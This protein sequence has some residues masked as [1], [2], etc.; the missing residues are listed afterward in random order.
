MEYGS[1]MGGRGVRSGGVRALCLLLPR[2]RDGGPRRRRLAAKGEKTRDAGRFQ[3]RRRASTGVSNISL[4]IARLP[5]RDPY[6]CALRCEIGSANAGWPHWKEVSNA[7]PYGLSNGSPGHLHSKEPG[8]KKHGGKRRIRPSI[9]GQE[10]RQ[11]GCP[12]A[13]LHCLNSSPP[14]SSLS[15]GKDAE[16]RNLAVVG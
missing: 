6:R 9:N 12:R 15:L 7:P 2:G 11:Q 3:S 4:P 1:R 14:G 5:G 16:T 8:G 13:R 10:V